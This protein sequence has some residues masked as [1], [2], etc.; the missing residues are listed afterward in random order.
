MV[1]FM[2]SKCS[3]AACPAP[4]ELVADGMDTCVFRITSKTAICFEVL[5]CFTEEAAFGVPSFYSGW[6]RYLTG[7]VGLRD[8][9]WHMQCRLQVYQRG[10]MDFI[11]SMGIKYRAEFSCQHGLEDLRV[12]GLTIGPRKNR[13][14][15]VSACTPQHPA[16]AAAAADAAPPAGEVLQQEQQQQQHVLPEQQQ[17]LALVCGSLFKDRVFIRDKQTRKLLL[18]FAETKGRQSQGLTGVEWEQ[19]QQRL[20]AGA[21]TQERLLLPL[22]E[23]ADTRPQGAAQQQQQQAA[24]LAGVGQDGGEAGPQPGPVLHTAKLQY[25]R[26]LFDLATTAP[27]VQV[28]RPS[29]MAALMPVLNTAEEPLR[30]TVLVQLQRSN[31]GLHELLAPYLGQQVPPEVR[32]LLV[33]VAR[34]AERCLQ[35][36]TASPQQLQRKAARLEER[37]RAGEAHTAAAAG[38]IVCV[39]QEWSEDLAMYLTGQYVCFTGGDWQPSDLGGSDVVRRLRHYAADAGYT[40][41]TASNCTKYK[42]STMQLVPGACVWWCGICGACRG[43]TIMKDA[44]SPRTI[45]TALYTRCQEAPQR[46]HCGQHTSGCICTPWAISY[47]RGAC[48]TS[49]RS[50]CCRLW[51]APGAVPSCSSSCCRFCCC[52][53][54]CVWPIL[55]AAP[56]SSSPWSS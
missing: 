34:V 1:Q 26:L 46:L 14:C 9:K 48:T 22:V 50:S 39:P 42:A 7:A 33:A 23:Q 49:S 15:I 51:P 45:F 8:R 2:S 6:R 12:D 10:V 54:L 44:E 4:Q 3:N 25:R 30:A 16:A 21:A 32:S 5:Y 28:M 27:A 31:P 53:S 18:R 24:G 52:Y 55:N 41:G 43:F 20:G 11:Q 36:T 29:S 13:V 40:M 47:S 19:L 37:A 17:P 38:G 35:P 56:S